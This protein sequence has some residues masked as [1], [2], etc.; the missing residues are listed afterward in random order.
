MLFYCIKLQLGFHDL[1]VVSVEDAAKLCPQS[2]P[3]VSNLLQTEDYKLRAAEWLG[4]AACEPTESYDMGP[5]GEDSRWETFGR[6]HDYLLKAFPLT[7]ANLTLSKPL[8]LA[9]HQDIV[10]VDPRTV[11]QWVHPPYSGYFEM[12]R[13][14]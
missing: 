7:H 5:I 4:G 11:D 10:P 14:D 1:D 3:E 6:L 2:N 8:L 12:I 9:A 13:A